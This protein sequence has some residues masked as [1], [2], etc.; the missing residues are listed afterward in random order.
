MQEGIKKKVAVHGLKLEIGN[1]KFGRNET[2]LRVECL[3]T[4]R[5]QSNG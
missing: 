2:S 5:M 1:W 4:G 3:Q